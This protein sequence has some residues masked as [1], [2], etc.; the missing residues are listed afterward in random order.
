LVADV[1]A[2]LGTLLQQVQSLLFSA[3]PTSRG[4]ALS[5]LNCAARCVVNSV[6]AATASSKSATAVAAEAADLLRESMKCIVEKYV[7]DKH[8][9]LPIAVLTDTVC[10]RF[11]DFFLPVVMPLLVDA[12]GSG[13][14]DQPRSYRMA[15]L[16]GVLGSIFKRHTS[17]TPSVRTVVVASFQRVLTQSGDCLFRGLA[18][19]GGEE[20]RLGGHV[21]VAVAPATGKVLSASQ[22]K[23]VAGCVQTVLAAV[24]SAAGAAS[25]V[26]GA[27]VRGCRDSVVVLLSGAERVLAAVTTTSKVDAP[28]MKSMVEGIIKAAHA[29][30]TALDAIPPPAA[31]AVV[32][33]GKAT[34]KAG[35][36]KAAATKEVIDGGVTGSTS[37]ATAVK[38]APKTIAVAELVPSPAASKDTA[39]ANGAGKKRG[40]TETVV[41]STQ[42]KKGKR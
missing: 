25:G 40:V 31:S 36:G 37:S 11:P 5:V 23:A 13:A 34:G 2:E 17:L 24:G 41:D 4:V 38:K 30:K 39:K 7:K 27:N 26:G 1:S 29:A 10:T 42:S 16:C 18:A 21:N 22:Q 14:G 6:T 8:S 33:N 12:L 19:R 15:E 20:E 32:A 3:E 28:A 9:R 35:K